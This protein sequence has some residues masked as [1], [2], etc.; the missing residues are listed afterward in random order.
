[1]RD[2]ESWNER[3]RTGRGPTTLNPRLQRYRHMLKPGRALDLACGIGQNAELLAGWDLILTDLADEALARAPGARV[4][5]DAAA[6]PFPPATFDTI[7]CT[8]FMPLGADIMALLRPG[9]TLFFESFTPDDK[10]YRPDF[11][12]SHHFSPARIPELFPGLEI[13]LWQEQDDGKR[14][15][16]T[17]IG[18][19]GG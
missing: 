11:D 2:R 6:L 12:P 1:M 14:V 3:Y 7:V 15:L 8:R 10:K 13:L 5:A 9:G 16:G 19:K 17:L 18:R 4:L